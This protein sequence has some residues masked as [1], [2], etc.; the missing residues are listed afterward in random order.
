MTVK[1]SILIINWNGGTYLKDC[2]SSIVSQKTSF[3]KEIIIFDNNSTDGSVEIIEKESKNLIIIKN[4]EN[5]G[6]ALG[7]NEALKF[8]KGIYVLLLNP[9]TI[10]KNENLLQIWMDYLDKNNEVALSGC[11]LIF[12]DGSHQIGDA[13]YKPNFCSLFSYTLFLSKIFPKIFK[14]IFLNKFYSDKPIEVDWICGADMMIKRAILEKT[15][16]FDDSIFMYAEDIEFGSRISSMGYKVMYLPF[17]EIIHLQGAT[18]RIH[19][20]AVYKTAWLKNLRKLFIDLNK[21]FLSGF[22]F[23]FCFS[24]NFFIKY[25]FSIIN[26]LIFWKKKDYE[27]LHQIGTYF[28]FCLKNFF[29]VSKND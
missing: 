24:L 1:L 4:H 18:Q 22:I 12:P 5:I 16:L 2:I 25:L 21:S 11:K 14:G 10:L 3:I 19:G 28:F 29:S 27:R 13:G 7:N 26:Y 23:D 9:D 15:Y 6:F 17:L 20:R 8:C